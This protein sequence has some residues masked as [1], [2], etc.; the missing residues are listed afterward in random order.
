[1]H[2]TV[3]IVDDDL[4]LF[5]EKLLQEEGYETQSAPTGADGLSLIQRRGA[6]VV[7]LDLRLPDASGLS[8][9]SEIKQIR[10]HL[11]VIIVT[12]YSDVGSAVEAMKRG[13]YDYIAKPY[14]ATKL[15]FSI[16]HALETV[17]LRAEIERLREAGA[18]EMEE[19]IGQ[20]PEMLRL[21]ELIARIAP[22]QVSVL[23][24]GPSGAGKEIAA[25]QI[26]RLSPRADRPFI[27][28][29]CAAIPDTLLESELFGY[30]AGAFTGA[31]KPKK[32]LIE[33]AHTGTLF[34]DE[35][36][37][38]KPE[39]Q[40][41]LLRVLED[42][43]VRRLG[44]TTDVPV[45][46]RILSASNRDMLGAVRANTFR[47]DLYYRLGVM[48]FTLPPLRE[49]AD[50]IPLF[51]A[52]FVQKMNR[53]MGCHVEDISEE[54]LALLKSYSWPGNIRELRNVIE[55]A[56]VLC[57][58]SQIGLEHLPAEISRLASPGP[59]PVADASAGS[60][61]LKERVAQFES[62]LIKRALEESGGNQT[63]AARKLGISRD[64]LRY[65]LK[66][67]QIS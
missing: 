34:L 3:L 44:S 2:Y 33:A 62:A 52:F 31:I 14:E 26:H 12:A 64:E 27:A 9:L 56:L 41:K 19:L 60:L 55:R 40:A 11:P 15:L 4:P 38:M 35:I 7:L 48:V 23:I 37:G 66:R 32:G 58:G 45:D 8:V 29:N 54:A 57:D 67:Y 24:Q 43:R 18:P 25:R 20:T 17:S 30:E 49:R 42:R 22:T 36:S 65:R 39:L 61:S 16:A 53:E 21:S 5:L 46:I 51:L 1:M 59:L 50:D 47:E 6:D 10:P 63:E 13:A 28:L